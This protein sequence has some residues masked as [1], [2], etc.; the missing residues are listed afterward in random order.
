MRLTPSSVVTEADLT[1]GKRALVQDSA[2]ASLAGSLYGGV[3]LVG[4]A[5]ELGATPSVVGLLAA[6]P[7]LAQ[8]A[9]LPGIALVERLRRRR[10]ITVITVTVARMIILSLAAV[11]FVPDRTAQLALVIAAQVAITVLGALAGCS[12]N[13]WLHQ[14]LPQE[15]LG[16]FFARR[17]F[18]GTAMGGLGALIAGLLVDHWPGDQRIEAYSIAFV[19]AA[20]AGFVS[21]FFL[22]RVPE[23]SM[24]WMGPEQ[25]I[26]ARIASPFRDDG[27]RPL[28]LLMGAWNFASNIAA[29][30]VAVFLL[31]QLGYGL[32]TVTTL[33]I[34]SQVSNALTLYLWGRISD[35]L[36]NKAILT[37]A[38]PVYFVSLFG[39]A[40]V[41]LPEPNAATLPL[42]YLVHVMMGAAA[43]GIGLA[44]GNLGLKLAPAGHGTAYL[45]SVSLTGAAAGGTAPMLGGVLAGWFAARELSLRVEWVSPTSTSD[46][47]VLQF[48]H[49]EF[50]F[51][52]SAAA[53][54]Y[55][56]HRLSSIREG[57]EISERAVM[58]E[59]GLEA[60]RTID[61]LSSVAGL[62]LSTVLPFG[63]LA[64]ERRG[65]SRR[66][67][68]D[69]AAERPG[70]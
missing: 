9:Q 70:K 57:R 58:Q 42:L 6:I 18:W 24:H 27:F 55:V 29:P 31:Q 12:L 54:L 10:A 15:G 47:T 45:A 65:A 43:G 63:W 44:T 50:L 26:A 37:V 35:R 53:G 8:A 17:L 1:L 60:V 61:Q 59:F 51:A 68:Q 38:L 22:A 30:F 16:A 4:F 11:P 36:S 2:W 67:A 14:L 69:E 49:W 28:I 48:Q 66:N 3:V 46:I 21:S 32:S 7:L 62:R 52:I 5:L 25:S 56:L 41:A 23:P 39:L 20:L 33:A 64:A 34:S 40:F 19:A 13:S